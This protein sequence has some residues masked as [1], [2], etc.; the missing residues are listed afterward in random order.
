MI[1][2]DASVVMELLLRTTRGNA[3]DDRLRAGR[4]TLHAPHLLDLEV[5]SVLRRLT[6]GGALEEMRSSEGLV[7]LAAMP[8]HRYPHDF[9]LKR[10]WELRGNLTAYDAAYVALAEALRAP[11]LT[12]DRR[13]A[14]AGGHRARIE[15][16]RS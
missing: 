9:L 1:V 2:L 6:A 4:F 8:I 7:D 3:A 11:L 10:V 13:L 12:C 15:M 14:R 5:A 16:L